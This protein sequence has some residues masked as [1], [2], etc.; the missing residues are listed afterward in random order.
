MVQRKT[1]VRRTPREDELHGQGDAGGAEVEDGIEDERPEQREAPNVMQVVEAAPE[2]RLLRRPVE[3]RKRRR[4]VAIGRCA[5]G[6][7]RYSG[8]L[9]GIVHREE[10]AHTCPQT[11]A[12]SPSGEPVV[13]GNDDGNAKENM[14]S[15]EIAVFR[16][17]G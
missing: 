12:W 8:R 17:T 5:E 15:R 1:P 13:I 4:H 10:R 6:L 3:R 7:Q 11:R 9:A 16:S 2:L 14:H